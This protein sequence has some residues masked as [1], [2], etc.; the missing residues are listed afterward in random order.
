MINGPAPSRRAALLT[1]SAARTRVLEYLQSCREPV[2][3]SQVAE[4]LGLHDNTARLHLEGL[5]AA[6]LAAQSVGEPAG[7]G[8]PPMMYVSGAPHDADPRIRDYAYLAAALASVV[9]QRS[10][11]PEEDARTAGLA[12]GSGLAQGT[13]VATAKQARNEVVRLL[14]ALG[15]DPAADAPARSVLLRRCP[16][17]DVARDHPGVVCQVHLGLVQGAL[18]RMGH[19]APDAQLH[20][21]AE[22]GGCRLRM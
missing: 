17:L 21:F 3:P 11:D 22:P 7:R 13:A 6:G 15:F 8:R 14:D 19:D 2:T 18:E 5:V 16:L 10:P 9:S 4:A 12:W 20:P 1:L